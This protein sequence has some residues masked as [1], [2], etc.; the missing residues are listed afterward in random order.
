MATLIISRTDAQAQGQRTYFTGDPC[1]YGHI[2]PRWVNGRKCVECGKVWS[3]AWK[4]RNRERARQLTRDWKAANPDAGLRWHQ[5]NRDKSRAAVRRYY[6]KNQPA[7]V[8]RATL[9]GR[10]RRA[11]KKGSGG[12]HTAADLVDILRMQKH[13]CAH[14]GCGADLRKVGKHLD[15]IMPLVLA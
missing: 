6:D 12:T 8:E 15:H 4:A 11:L 14:P 2:S 7:M 5:E 10:K 13:R 9:L 3:N 1:A